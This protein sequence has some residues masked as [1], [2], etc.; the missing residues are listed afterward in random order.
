MAV[1]LNQHIAPITDEVAK[2]N[3]FLQKQTKK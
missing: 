2:V 3:V 1:S